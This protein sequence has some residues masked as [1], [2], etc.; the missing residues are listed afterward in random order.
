LEAGAGTVVVVLGSNEKQHR[1]VLHGLPVEIFY[2]SAWQ[3][4]IGHSLK[5]GLQFLLEKEPVVDAV[6]VAVCDQ[7][8]LTGD[9][10]RKLILRHQETEKPIVA[11][12][13]SKMPGVPVLFHKTYFPGLM[14][15]PDE[16]G[17]KK[18]ILRNAADVS[19]VDFPGGEVDLDT[20]DDYDRFTNR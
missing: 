13:Y 19:E 6:V 4:G 2:N 8:L 14:A 3:K 10:I 9:N 15:L 16:E 17:A 5:T 18:I 7:P 20:F 1:K 12:R 11:S